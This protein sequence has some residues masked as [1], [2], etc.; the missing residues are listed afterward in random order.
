MPITPPTAQPPRQ[1][2]GQ[3][4]IYLKDTYLDHLDT[5]IIA[6]GSQLGRPWIAVEQCIFHPQG[7][8]QPADKGWLDQYEIVPFLDRDTGLVLASFFGDGSAAENYRIG[9]RVRTNID[10]A[11]RMSNAAHHTA[12]HV[13]EAAG[14]T[15][16]WTLAANIHFPG[17]SRIEF[18][19]SDARLADDAGRIHATEALREVVQ[20]TIGSDLRVDADVDESGLRTVRI[21]ELHAALCG[22]THLRRLGELGNLTIPTIKIKRGRIRVSY[23]AEP[24]H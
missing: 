21:G 1:Q 23:A 22:G 10:L 5:F 12:G 17:Q 9:Q 3:D 4:C 2:A 19:S 18:T 14:R 24:T 13:I 7:G 16:G 15:Q 8:G 11:Q 6:R 20:T